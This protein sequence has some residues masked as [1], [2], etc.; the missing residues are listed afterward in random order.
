MKNVGIN[1]SKKMPV[2][3]GGEDP[4]PIMRARRE[5]VKQVNDIMSYIQHLCIF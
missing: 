3:Q 2:I 1:A 4:D 5:F